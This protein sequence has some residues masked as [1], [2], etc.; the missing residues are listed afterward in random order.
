MGDIF[1]SVKEQKENNSAEGVLCAERKI[2]DDKQKKSNK[3]SSKKDRESLS[4]SKVCH[5][6]FRPVMRVD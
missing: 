4:S 2:R 5:I 1:Q 3:E 6:V